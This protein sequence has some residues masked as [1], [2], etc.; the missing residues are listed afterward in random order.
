M[1]SLGMSCVDAT[2]HLELPAHCQTCDGR[3]YIKRRYS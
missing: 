3:G 1:V 2:L